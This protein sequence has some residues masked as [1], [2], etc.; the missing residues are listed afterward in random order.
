MP[1]GD[2]IEKRAIRAT[3]LETLINMVAAGQGITLVPAMALSGGWT[4][5][6]RVQASKLADS[7]ASRRIYLTFRKS[8][9]RRQLLEEMAEVIC[10]HLPRGVDPIEQAVTPAEE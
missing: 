7:T 9:P 3:S 6:E 5:D 2:A 1:D 4:T 10:S 8:F